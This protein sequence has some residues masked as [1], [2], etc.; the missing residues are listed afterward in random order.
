M[1]TPKK[2]TTKAASAE[3]AK[4]KKDTK[5]AA[6]PKDPPAPVA[7]A[8]PT[9]PTPTPPPVPAGPSK[10]DLDAAIARATSAEKKAADADKRAH[11]A[12]RRAHD[13]DKRVA[14]AEKKAADADQRAE[15]L[16][17]HVQDAEGK[18]AASQAVIAD[19]RATAGQNAA[20]ADQLQAELV[21]AREELTGFKLR[22]PKCGKNM[23]EEQYEG[24][25]ID[26]CT[27][28]GGVYFDAGE[29]E[30]LIQKIAENQQKPGFWSGLFK[31]KPKA[32]TGTAPR[33]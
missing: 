2:T 13:L 18:V 30:Q 20:R 29:T 21:K 14:D 24:I 32:D 12:D 10:A 27:G 6:A 33:P 28:C 15:A 9:P 1:A 22:C 31:K 11:D 25:A 23:A 8:A 26:R 3:P 4:A 5:K 7:A 17:K 19:L 16:H